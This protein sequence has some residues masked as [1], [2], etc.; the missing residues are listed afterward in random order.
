MTCAYIAFTARGLALAQ[1][2]AAVC[3]GSA[4]PRAV[5]AMYAQV[6]G[7]SPCGTPL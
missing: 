2:L 1:Q 6:I 3:P 7:P 4:S 5:N